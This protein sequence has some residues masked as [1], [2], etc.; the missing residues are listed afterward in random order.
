VCRRDKNHQP[1]SEIS[2]GT[3]TTGQ[4][5]ISNFNLAKYNW[6][7]TLSGFAILFDH[8]GVS[9]I[10]DPSLLMSQRSRQRIVEQLLPDIKK[11]KLIKNLITRHM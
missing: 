9:C 8:T 1:D 6:S 3:L 10:F 2:Y 4:S 11:I 5:D 7:G